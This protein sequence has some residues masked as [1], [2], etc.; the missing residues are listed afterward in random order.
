MDS[1][2]A[3]RTEQLRALFRQNPGVLWLNVA[4]AALT[5]AALWVS[6]SKA[7]LVAWVLLTGLVAFGRARLIVRYQ[8]AQPKDTELEAWG[9]RFV[10]GSMA[11]GAVWGLASVV[12]F[13]AV[14]GPSQLVFGFAIAGMTAAGAG[15]WS[16]HLPVFWGYIGCAL[17]PF[18]ARTLLVGDWAHL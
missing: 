14:D 17:G 6:A 10:L 9:Q 5:S 7:L 2:A 11:A 18:L 15:T 16:C 12:F 4:V 13:D 8:S 3:V 1:G